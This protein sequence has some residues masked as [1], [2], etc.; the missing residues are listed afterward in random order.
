VRQI[1]L[2]GQDR[3]AAFIRRAPW[4]HLVA[5]QLE[6]SLIPGAGLLLRQ[7][8]HRGIDQR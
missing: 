5:Q 6:F 4:I 8:V 7:G 2:G 1:Q 3:L